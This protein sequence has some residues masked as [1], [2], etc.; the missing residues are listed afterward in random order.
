MHSSYN[1][2]EWSSDNEPSKAELKVESIS[3]MEESKDDVSSYS[4]I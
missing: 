1:S 3:Q 2:L 4:R